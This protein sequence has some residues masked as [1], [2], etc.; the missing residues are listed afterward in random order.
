[1]KRI[2]AAAMSLFILLSL[3]S[4]AET[5]EPEE[6]SATSAASEKQ[7]ID[8]SE[9]EAPKPE[10]KKTILARSIVNRT[11]NSGVVID[12][13]VTGLNKDSLS[14][15]TG[16]MRIFSANEVVKALG[17]EQKDIISSQTDYS[18]DSL[19]PGDS[20]YME[21]ADGKTLMC[22]M[23]QIQYET[24]T[25]LAARGILILNGSK[26]NANKFLTGKEL[27]FATIEQAK[28]EINRVLEQLDISVVNE[29]GCYT[30]DF[31]TLSSENERLYAL[32][33][34][35]VKELD[36][37]M[38]SPEKIAIGEEDACYMFYYPIAIDGLPVSNQF[39]GA[40]GDGSLMVGTELVVCY[41]KDGIAEFSLEYQPEV[42]EKTE[43]KPII[44]LEE[45]LKI[46]EE[47]YDS[48]I[49]NG[50]YLIYDIKLEYIAKPVF[51]K[52]YTYNLIPAWHFSIEHS[53][54]LKKGDGSEAIHHETDIEYNQFNAITGEELPISLGGA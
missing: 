35:E 15:Y 52:E 34:E 24:N 37:E 14:T 51:E 5:I 47:K 10:S 30:M 22:D 9:N 6:A 28:A 26:K 45:M 43:A 27:D 7:E 4:C 11:L 33:L 48:L 16:S 53:F 49:L 41:S 40:D 54:D 36:M 46:V 23:N 42:I 38:F 17:F 8:I 3:C 21:F 29:P 12:A 20:V 25:S 1:M 19:I 13:D 50:E 39:S 31:E 44:P 2:L 18:L 32:A